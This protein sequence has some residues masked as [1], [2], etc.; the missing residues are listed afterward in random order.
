METR[1][2][3]IKVVKNRMIS[4]GISAEQALAD[5]VRMFNEMAYDNIAAADVAYEVA[6]DVIL[7]K[8]VITIDEERENPFDD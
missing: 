8:E 3:V 5:I 7:G 1:E 2:S 6:K 4:D